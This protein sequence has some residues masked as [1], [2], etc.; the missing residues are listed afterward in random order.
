MNRSMNAAV[1]EDIFL[2]CF[3]RQTL[4]DG[5][6]DET[7]RYITT[8]SAVLPFSKGEIVCEKGRRPG[9]LFCLVEGQVKL[10]VLSAQGNERVVEIVTPGKVFGEALIFVDDPFPVHAE[11][12]GR[13]EVIFLRKNRILDSIRRFPDFGMAML[14]VVSERQNKLLRDVEV[15]C[16]QSANRRVAGFLVDN[17]DEE[18]PR[19]H[20]RL[21]A[22]KAVVASTLNLTPET[23]SRELH[24]LA[25]V[26]LIS[27]DRRTIEVKDPDALRSVL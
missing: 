24:Q 2:A 4:F 22:G 20:V 7:I 6:D 10:A 14:S 18:G 1:Q 17:M 19:P 11:A 23:F 12:L 5:L 15:C 16:L 21:T 26:G 8:G 9:G 27:V 25:A 3:K 13:C